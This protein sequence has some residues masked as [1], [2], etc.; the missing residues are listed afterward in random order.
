MQEE[1]KGQR[2]ECERVCGMGVSLV[3]ARGASFPAHCLFSSCVRD[4]KLD[5]LCAV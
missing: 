3:K 4:D 5:R 2:S 1:L